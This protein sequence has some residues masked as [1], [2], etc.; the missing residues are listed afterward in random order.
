MPEPFL[1]RGGATLTIGGES[2]R[3]SSFEAMSTENSAHL[4]Q[5]CELQTDRM[6]ALTEQKAQRGTRNTTAPRWASPI[7]SRS[8]PLQEGLPR[9]PAPYH[10]ALA[11]EKT[12]FSIHS[13]ADI[14][15]SRTCQGVNPN[16]ISKR[17]ISVNNRN[18][19]R[20]SRSSGHVHV[21]NLPTKVSSK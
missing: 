11:Q 12:D 5:Q 7:V 18:V 8:L 2:L 19:L 15:V 3:L 9:K 6:H 20:L 17:R 10:Y 14:R 4:I 21:M 16:T 13:F 1:P